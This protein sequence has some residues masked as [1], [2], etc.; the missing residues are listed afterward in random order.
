MSLTQPE[1]I[2]SSAPEPG[3]NLVLALSGGGLRATLFHLG[4]F[5][6]LAH[7]NRLRDVS[8]IVSVSGG[9]ILAA[10]FGKDWQTAI[11]DPDGFIDVAT[12]LVKFARSDIRHSVLIPWL[13]SRLWLCWWVR[14]LGRTARLERAYRKHFG[15]TT[16][17]DLANLSG[18][19]LALVATDAIKEE[20]I[21]FTSDHVKRFPMNH[22]DGP[23]QPDQITAHGIHVSLAV[24]ASSCF[25]PVFTRM[26]L[27]HDDLGLNYSEFKETLSL[28]DGGVSGNRGIKVLLALRSSKAFRAQKIYICDAECAQR[29][30]PSGTAITD[31][32]AQGRVIS[33]WERE[34]V[35]SNPTWK[36]ISLSERTQGFLGLSHRA[37]T[38]LAG[39]RTD[40]DAP[41]WQEMHALMLHGATLANQKVG[42]EITTTESQQHIQAVISQ[43]LTNAGAPL[44]HG[45]PQES[46]LKGCYKRPIARVLLHLFLVLCV[47]AAEL[48]IIVTC[49]RL[50][51]AWLFADSARAI[52]AFAVKEPSNQQFIP[53]GSQIYLQGTGLSPGAALEVRVW[54]VLPDGTKVPVPQGPAELDIAANGQWRFKWVVFGEDG[55]HVIEVR[56]RRN[57]AGTDL[58]VLIQVFVGPGMTRQVDEPP[59]PAQIKI[60]IPKMRQPDDYSAG[61]TALMAIGKYSGLGPK[62]IDEWKQGV[63]A[64]AEDGVYYKN[65]V[66]YAAKLGM[67]PALKVAMTIDDLKQVLDAGKPVIC[68]I[69]AYADD[70]REYDDPAKNSNGHYV[71]AVGYQNDVFFF[72]DP[73]LPNKYGSLPWRD[74]D[75]RWRDNEGTSVKPEIFRHLGI[76]IQAQPAFEIIP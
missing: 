2:E 6:Y 17:E 47:L 57:Q 9:S 58:S 15:E 67:Q 11:R 41:S 38:Q 61:A 7:T 34:L 44:Y 71:V 74:L 66:Q 39:F 36:T 64:T 32:N 63:R 72:M 5:I 19:R 28:N 60:R 10:H 65:I 23:R 69:Q 1:Q 30:R 31:V 12:R 29:R 37:Q 40:L 22:D 52:A 53:R 59:E 45:T 42:G 25:P 13:W 14:K 18:L 76:V 8:G 75:K 51:T 4:I 3:E 55:E 26:Y 21:A 62:T 20:R 43:I 35:K 73:S 27:H 48:F 50:L 56:P 49:C 46:E 70:P 68:S 54:Q 16:L 24:A 33:E